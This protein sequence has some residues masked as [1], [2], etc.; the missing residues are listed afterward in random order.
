MPACS[1]RAQEMHM[2]EIPTALGYG[3][4][5]FCRKGAVEEH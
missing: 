5:L 3:L 1:M 4:N 2:G